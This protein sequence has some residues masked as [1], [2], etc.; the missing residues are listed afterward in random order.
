MPSNLRNAVGAANS[1]SPTRS[2]WQKNLYVSSIY[3]HGVLEGDAA[4]SRALAGASRMSLTRHSLKPFFGAVARPRASRRLAYFR[5]W[6]KADIARKVAAYMSSRRVNGRPLGCAG[7]FQHLGCGES[8]RGEM[9]RGVLS[10][11]GGAVWG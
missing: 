10:G 7:I 11:R 5:R 4:V 2:Y 6:Q 8:T 9:R 3:N 1:M